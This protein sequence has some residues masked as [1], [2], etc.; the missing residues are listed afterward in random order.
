MR[1]NL[2]DLRDPGF[3]QRMW[4]IY[5]ENSF[6]YKVRRFENKRIQHIDRKLKEYYGTELKT[7]TVTPGGG[8][9][10]SRLNVHPDG[11]K[12]VD[13]SHLERN[14]S[15][16]QFPHQKPVTNDNFFLLRD[17]NK[18][19]DPSVAANIQMNQN[20]IHTTE[21]YR[22]NPHQLHSYMSVPTDTTRFR[23]EKLPDLV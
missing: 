21:P 15:N 19:T 2:E 11:Y 23:V 12:T 3:R 20:T 7:N 17:W 14:S 9:A 4:N 6:S 18:L 5:L 1:R 22:P 10:S 8:G 16:S 13:F